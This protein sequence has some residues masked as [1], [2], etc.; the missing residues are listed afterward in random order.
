MNKAKK[1][2]IVDNY[3]HCEKIVYNIERKYLRTKKYAKT[4]IILSFQNKNFD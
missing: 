3:S 4:I 2:L 1:L